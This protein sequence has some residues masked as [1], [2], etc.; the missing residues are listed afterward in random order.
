MSYVWFSLPPHVNVSHIVPTKEF[1]VVRPSAVSSVT[2]VGVSK[3]KKSFCTLQMLTV[4]ELSI[5]KSI[6]S[7]S[8]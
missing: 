7:E 3:P 8:H 5:T 6:P 4:A 1:L 2:F